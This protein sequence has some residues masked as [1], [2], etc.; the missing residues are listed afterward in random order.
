MSQDCLRPVTTLPWPSRSPNLPPIEHI[1]DNL[2]RRV[3]HPTSFNELEAR[4]QEILNE[5]SQDII[6]NLCASVPDRIASCIRARVGSTGA[7]GSAFAEDNED[8]H[9]HNTKCQQTTTF[10][11]DDPARFPQSIAS[12]PQSSLL[13]PVPSIRQSKIFLASQNKVAVIF[14]ADKV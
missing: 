12:K 14:L 13:K 10:V 7:N 11:L 3:E 5:I 4:L 1:W 9:C 6:Q 8:E 2:G